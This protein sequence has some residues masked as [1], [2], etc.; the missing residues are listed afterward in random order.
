MGFEGLARGYSGDA[1]LAQALDFVPAVQTP[2]EEAEHGEVAPAA[3]PPDP[4]PL[5]QD[6]FP[7]PPAIRH[8]IPIGSPQITPPPDQEQAGNR[9]EGEQAEL[10]RDH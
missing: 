6:V 3:E 9:F 5:G 4:P 7:E 10:Q 8:G 1:E 2:V